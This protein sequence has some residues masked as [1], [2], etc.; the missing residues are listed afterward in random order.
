M[1][2]VFYRRCVMATRT[3][4]LRLPEELDLG[5]ESERRLRGTSF[6]E[7]AIGLLREAL[8]M[9]R[10][11][12]IYF[13]D[14]LDARRAAVAGT[15]IEVWEVVATYKS[16]GEDHEE[17]RKS[18]PQLSE[19]QLKAALSY[20]ELYPEE[21]DARIEREGY[22]TPERVWGEFPFTRPGEA[23]GVRRNRETG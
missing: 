9:R 14:G 8:R 1:C 20:Y 17:L 16:V 23:D 22:W 21:V 4:G 3:R 2:T 18:Y 5:I 11:P 6:S 10:A 13:V 19:T 7:E 12:G 15:G